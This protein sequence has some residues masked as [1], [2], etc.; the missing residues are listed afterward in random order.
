MADS[1]ATNF[2][3]VTQELILATVALM[4]QTAVMMNLVTRQPISKGHDRVEIPRM[5]ATFS[6][7]T[8]TEGDEIVN[9][10]AYDLTSTTIQPTLRA[11]YVRASGR[12]EYFS[13]DNVMGF[14]T[15]ELARAQ[16]QD[17][18][19]DL[20]AEFANF[21]TTDVG[22][23]NRNARLADV[24]RASRQLDEIAPASGG[25]SPRPRAL[26][27]SPMQEEMLLVDAGALGMLSTAGTNTAPWIPDGLS[28][29]ILKTY[30]VGSWFGIP[31][32]RD[33]YLVSASSAFSGGL[34]P[35]EALMLAISKEWDVKVYDESEW[36]GPIIRCVADYNSGIPSFATWG[37]EV[38]SNATAP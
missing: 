33:G 31:V 37:V 23:T 14:L 22:A 15:K 6:V 13:R 17:I 34:F 20:L 35:K 10:Q 25:P 18:D 27:V 1:L 3:E 19:T 32:Y 29:D 12:A 7:N 9:G 24:R 4:P 5:N 11:M 2:A 16:G 28:A 21:T 38:L 36:I 30:H 8:P 26:V